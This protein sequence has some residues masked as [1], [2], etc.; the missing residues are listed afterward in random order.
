MKLPPGCGSMSGK[1]VRLG[2]SLYG[3][4]QASRTF[5][6]RLV[7]DLKTIGFEQCL[8]DPSVL[9]FMMGDEVI[10]MNVI[11][12]DD[13]LYAGLKRLAQYLLQELWEPPSDEESRRG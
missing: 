6:K 12:V 1:V 13:I 9:R 7:Q 10:R 2:K 3:L 11:H 8:T 5:N 4:R